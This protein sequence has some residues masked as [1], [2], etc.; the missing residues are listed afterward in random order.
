MS[1]TSSYV[2]IPQLS[3]FGD[4]TRKLTVT[5]KQSFII[6]ILTLTTLLTL[7]FLCAENL[8]EIENISNII[9]FYQNLENCK[10]TKC[11]VSLCIRVFQRVPASQKKQNELFEKGKMK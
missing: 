6:K 8:I 11:I 5:E 2:S 10:I 4:L 7:S 1:Q 9:Q 3:C